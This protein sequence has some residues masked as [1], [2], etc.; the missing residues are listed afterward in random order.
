MQVPAIAKLS[1]RVLYTR[2]H[3]VGNEGFAVYYARH[4]LQADASMSRYITHRRMDAR[5]TPDQWADRSSLGHYR[6]DEDELVMSRKGKPMVA[7]SSTQPRPL[8]CKLR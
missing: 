7:L 8:A 2:A 6:V 4:S 1:N 5:A 3:I